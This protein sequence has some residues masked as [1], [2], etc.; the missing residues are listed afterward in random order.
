M[1]KKIFLFFTSIWM[2]LYTNPIFAGTGIEGVDVA[3]NRILGI[4]RRIGYWIILISCIYSVIGCVKEKDLKKLG[5]V[6]FF[7]VILYAA[8]YFVPYMLRQVEG[9]F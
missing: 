8:L 6:I 9:I 2:F 1:K 3:G 7:Y 5:N 4:V